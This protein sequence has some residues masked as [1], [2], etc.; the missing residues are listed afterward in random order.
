MST[1]KKRRKPVVKEAV[2]HCRVNADIKE[3]AVRAAADDQR[4]VAS[5]VE[6]ALVDLLQSRSYLSGKKR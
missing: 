5:L 6:K 4:T 3:A 2:L 1:A